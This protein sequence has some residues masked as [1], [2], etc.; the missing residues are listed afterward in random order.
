MKAIESVMPDEGGQPLF[1]VTVIVEV[2]AAGGVRLVGLADNVRFGGRT[3]LAKFA[4]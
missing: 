1:P 2:E 4:A 3:E